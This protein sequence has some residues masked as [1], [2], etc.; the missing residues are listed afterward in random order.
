MHNTHTHTFL[1]IIHSVC[2]TSV[3]M[4]SELIIWQWITSYGALLYYYLVM[5]N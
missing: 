2:I 4:A 3:H 5:D 1:N